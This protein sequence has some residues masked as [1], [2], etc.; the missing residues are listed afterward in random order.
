M[1]GRASFLNQTPIPPLRYFLPLHDSAFVFR[2]HQVLPH[3]CGIRGGSG[4]T[5]L[6]IPHGP[7][8]GLVLGAHTL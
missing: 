1:N 7:E 3:E 8:L 2:N 5:V 6:L 4:G